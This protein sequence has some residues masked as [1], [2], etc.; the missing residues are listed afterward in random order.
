MTSSIFDIFNYFILILLC[1]V[2]LYPFLYTMSASISDPLLVMQNR[3]VLFPKGIN[4]DAYQ[5]VFQKMDI[6]RGFYNSVVYTVVGTAINI[7]FTSIT[8][9][10]LSRKEFALRI[11]ITKFIVFTMFF[12]GGLIPTFLVVRYLGMYNSMWALVVPVAIA[13][14][15][16]LILKSFF[17]QIPESLIESARIDGSHDLYILFKI[18]FPLSL[19]ALATIGLFYAVGHWNNFFSALIFITDNKLYPL[20]LMIR[21]ISILENIVDV[22]TIDNSILFKNIKYAVIFI[23]SLP[24]ICLYPFIQRYFVKGVTIGS[25]KE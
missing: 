25:L 22:V 11:F 4:F 10:A 8:A 23:S 12:S 1:V 13:T 14:W 16:L 17:S 6:G 9:Y 15:N 2:T 3:I 24:M 18:I 20:Q 19:P 7:L 21:N 5:L